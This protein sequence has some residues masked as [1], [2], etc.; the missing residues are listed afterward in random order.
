MLPDPITFSY[1]E[2]GTAS[3]PF[4]VNKLSTP[5]AGESVY[6]R[7]WNYPSGRLQ[8]RDDYLFR[9]VRQ[10]DGLVRPSVSCRRTSYEDVDDAVGWTRFV[11]TISFS[12]RENPDLDDLEAALAVSR[13]LCGWLGDH[14][15]EDNLL[16]V[17][18]GEL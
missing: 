13:S 11:T 9:F 6:Y 18:N 17:V 4:S 10:S 3:F 7:N 12:V 14:T 15:Q 2:R 8:H 16:R 1:Y 5:K